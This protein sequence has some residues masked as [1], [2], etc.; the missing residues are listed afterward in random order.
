VFAPIS[1]AQAARNNIDTAAKA[2]QEAAPT[3]DKAINWLTN[4]WKIAGIAVAGIA[5]ARIASDMLSSD[6]LE[7]P[8]LKSSQRLNFR[9]APLP[10]EPMVQSQMPTVNPSSLRRPTAYVQPIN[11]T[12]NRA[13]YSADYS[14]VNTNAM[15]FANNSFGN[16]SIQDSRSYNSNWQMQNIA[17]MAGDSDFIHPYMPV[18]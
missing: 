18:V 11:G 1:Q 4:N 2:A 16:I 12:Y 9:P 10:P 17:N 13:Q 5:V 7:R 8:P 15:S 14:T 6:E 3:V